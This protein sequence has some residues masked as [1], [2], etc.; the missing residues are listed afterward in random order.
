MILLEQ[1]IVMG[2]Y[3][4]RHPLL[5]LVPLRLRLSEGKSSSK[6]RADLQCCW[7]RKKLKFVKKK[8][9][10]LIFSLPIDIV[11]IDVVLKFYKAD[12]F[13]G[14]FDTPI[15]HFRFAGKRKRINRVTR[16]K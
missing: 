6:I 12:A 15:G 3:T 7:F 9:M 11:T 13:E 16:E 4:L 14:I 1:E 5:F 2:I 10:T 8:D